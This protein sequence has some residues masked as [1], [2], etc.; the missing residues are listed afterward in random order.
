MSGVPSVI[1]KELM[2]LQVFI[3]TKQHDELF[4]DLDQ[5]IK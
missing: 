5:L 4:E 3:S 1:Y 2:W